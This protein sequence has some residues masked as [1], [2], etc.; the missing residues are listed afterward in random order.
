MAINN[1]DRS[2]KATN[3]FNVITINEHLLSNSHSHSLF[4]S[5]SQSHL[6]STTKLLSSSDFN[7]IR[8]VKANKTAKHRVMM[9]Q[10]HHHANNKTKQTTTT[11][12][13]PSVRL[14]CAQLTQLNWHC[15][16]HLIILLMPLFLLN[17]HTIQQTLANIAGKLANQ[18]HLHNN[19]TIERLDN[20]AFEQLNNWSVDF[21]CCWWYCQCRHDGLRLR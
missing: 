16:Q 19:T 10:R 13:T 12:T 6:A 5:H 8:A 18:S 20:W 7:I 2:P 21:D 1:R 9:M 3:P 14:D 15:K 4:H 11:T 17:C